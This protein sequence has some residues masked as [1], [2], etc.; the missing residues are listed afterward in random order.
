MPCYVDTL[1]TGVDAYNLN[2][3]PKNKTQNLDFSLCGGLPPPVNINPNLVADVIYWLDKQLGKIPVFGHN[4]FFK[5]LRRMAYG[6]YFSV[7]HVSYAEI[8]SILNI[9]ETF[10]RPLKGELDI[11]LLA[12]A[13]LAECQAIIDHG[14]RPQSKSKK[15]EKSSFNKLI[16]E[17]CPNYIG[18]SDWKAR[19]IRYLSKESSLNNDDSLT[20]VQKVISYFSQ[21]YPRI[22]DR[23]MLIELASKVSDSLELYGNTLDAFDFARPYFKGVATTQEE[24][25]EIYCRSKINLNNNT[26][27]LGLHSRTLECMGVGGFI[28][29]HESP[30]DRKPGGMLTAFEPGVHFGSYTPENFHEQAERWLKDDKKRIQIGKKAKSIIKDQHCWQHR[31]QQI[32]N[33]LNK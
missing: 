11:H 9:V 28:F 25:L 1:F 4:D 32:L 16:K 2:F 29:M 30:H 6:R 12:E 19:L 31:A 3:N 7:E 27:G 26:H 17:H 21:S 20:S 13:M 15:T 18:R 22:M 23:K 5:I 10:Y 33:D 24:L 14:E 8:M